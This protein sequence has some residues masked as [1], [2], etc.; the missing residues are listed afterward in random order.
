[1]SYQILACRDKLLANALKMFG[2]R[3][4]IGSAAS[5]LMTSIRGRNQRLLWR[6][7]ILWM[8]TLSSSRAMQSTLRG[9]R[10]LP[11]FAILMATRI[12]K[13]RLMALVE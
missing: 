5:N 6:L 10:I 4:L 11:T 9:A 13:W 2:D 12:W 1:M 3:F 8:K 7:R